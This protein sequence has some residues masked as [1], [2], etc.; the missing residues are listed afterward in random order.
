MKRCTLAVA[1]ILFYLPLWSQ[2]VPLGE[3]VGR[4]HTIRDPLYGWSARFPEDWTVHGV[5][6]WGDRETTLYLG[7]R[8]APNAHATLYHKSH[9]T[10]Q[11]VPADA[12]SFLRKE[13]ERHAVRRIMNG[14]KTYAPQSGS[15]AFKTIGGHPALRFVAH[16]SSDDRTHCEYVVRVASD[17]GVAQIVLRVP[18]AQ[19]EVVRANFEAMA[20]TLLLP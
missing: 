2:S 8:A 5:T 19:F 1:T 12:E 7:S 20:E 15:F 11:P 6:R 4:D 14:L 10:P 17:R 16:F 18:L 3:I 9:A 13:A